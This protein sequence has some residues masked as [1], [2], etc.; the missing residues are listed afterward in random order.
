M[1][2]SIISRTII[3][4]YAS[5]LFYNATTKAAESCIVTLPAAID[6]ADRADRPSVFL[7]GLEHDGR[8]IHDLHRAFRAD[9]HAQSLV[10]IFGDQ[11]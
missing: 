6:N 7:D 9:E 11:I 2:E 8:L 5:V 1:K 3:T 10:R 4:N